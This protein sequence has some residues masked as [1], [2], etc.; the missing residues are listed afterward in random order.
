[1]WDFLNLTFSIHF[2]CFTSHILRYMATL[3]GHAEMEITI[4]A[5]WSHSQLFQGQ[6]LEG[7]GEKWKVQLE[8]D[9]EGLFVQN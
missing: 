5:E 1:M 4:T 9:H 3:L 7:R 8:A 6:L 2:L